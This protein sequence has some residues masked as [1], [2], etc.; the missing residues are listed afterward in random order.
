MHIQKS[1]FCNYIRNDKHSFGKAT[2]FVLLE[3]SV[4]AFVSHTEDGG[5]PGFPLLALLDVIWMGG[6]TM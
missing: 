4:C 1:A 2:L 6:W 3:V 5:G